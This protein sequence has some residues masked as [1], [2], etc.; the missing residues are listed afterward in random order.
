MFT[1]KQLAEI[2]NRKVFWFNNDGD[3]KESAP[4]LRSL[5]PR[6]CLLTNATKS[7]Q[8]LNGASWLT[9]QILPKQNPTICYFHPITSSNM[10]RLLLLPLALYLCTPTLS[11]PSTH[12]RNLRRQHDGTDR[13]RRRPGRLGRTLQQRCHYRQ[14][15]ADGF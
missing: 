15:G 2:V 11:C 9:S 8:W 5:L 4:C 6:L 3:I 14:S 13:R 7:A 10:T 1:N 12:Q